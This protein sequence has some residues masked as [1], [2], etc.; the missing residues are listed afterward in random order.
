MDGVKVS[1]KNGGLEKA[2]G[3]RHSEKQRIDIVCEY[4]TPKLVY[5][6]IKYF[7]EVKSCRKFLVSLV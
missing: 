5:I 2:L 7:Q 4:Y 1:R 3:K 6:V